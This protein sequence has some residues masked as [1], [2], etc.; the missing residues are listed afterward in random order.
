MSYL[1]DITL[2]LIRVLES[3]AF[4]KDPVRLTGYEA[5]IDFWA[6]EI[7][8]CLDCL[9]GY[10]LRCARLREA[11]LT[12]GREHGAEI[13]PALLASTVTDDDLHRLQGRMQ[14]AA[15]RFMRLCAPEGRK[16][17]FE[18]FLGIQITKKQY[19]D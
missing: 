6:G 7:R 18:Q 2:A 5:T 4:H 16:K 8:H 15:T 1:D 3:A 17:E 9:A 14:A 19:S 11:R 10:E 12:W 13:D